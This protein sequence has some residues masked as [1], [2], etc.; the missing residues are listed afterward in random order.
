M[1]RFREPWFALERGNVHLYQ[2]PGLNIRPKVSALREQ[3]LKGKRG[4]CLDCARTGGETAI[5][6]GCRLQGDSCAA[7]IEKAHE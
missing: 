4:I 2:E 1:Q 5:G 6:G 3:L 7:R